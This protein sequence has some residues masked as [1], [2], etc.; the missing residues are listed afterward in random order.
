[1]SF[2]RRRHQGSSLPSSRPDGNG[3]SGIGKLLRFRNA[4]VGTDHRSTCAKLWRKDGVYISSAFSGSFN[5][6]LLQ[7]SGLEIAVG[8][9][10]EHRWSNRERQVRGVDQEAV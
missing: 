4:R 9:G 8:A 2:C 3:S 1:M 7:S 5:G 6:H 10:P